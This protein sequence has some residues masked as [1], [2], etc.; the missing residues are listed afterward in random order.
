MEIEKREIQPIQYNVK[1]SSDALEPIRELV[2]SWDIPRV[3]RDERYCTYAYELTEGEAKSILRQ[4]SSGTLQIQGKGGPQIRSL[5]MALEGTLS[6]GFDELPLPHCGSD[7]AGKGDYFG[8]LVVAGVRVDKALLE[9]FASLGVMD[10][11]RLSDSRA[12]SLARKISDVTQGVAVL[13]L[14][15][16]TYNDLYAKMRSEGKNLNDLLAWAHSRV[17]RDLEGSA[18]DPDAPCTFA[19]VDKFASERV[20]LS[21]MGDSRL[22]VKQIE[23]G[24]RYPSVAAAS[25]L[26][27]A[28]FLSDLARLS[29]EIGVRL[30]KGAGKAVD[31][32][33]KQ[34]VVDNGF[35]ALK[36]VAKLHFSNTDRVR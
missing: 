23:R 18:A 3:A 28:R 15:P 17:L 8:P 26:A 22:R 21:R 12:Q 30:P 10:S 16:T 36:D 14:L 9:R 19:V 24:E 25:I 29:E 1:L 27:R 35:D 7:E 13:S 2:E 33:A 31:S 32:V 4:Y 20:L 11:K 6:A 34:I 5:V